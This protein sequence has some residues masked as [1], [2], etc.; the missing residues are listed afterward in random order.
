MSRNVL[1]H[2]EHVDS[3]SCESD[4]GRKKQKPRRMETEDRNPR[5]RETRPRPKRAPE[6]EER[7]PRARETRA[8]PQRAPETVERQPRVLETE[9]RNPR[10]Q[11]LETRQQQ[12]VQIDDEEIDVRTS[13]RQPYVSGP[14]QTVEVPKEVKDTSAAFWKCRLE[15]CDDALEVNAPSVEFLEKFGN[16][17]VGICGGC[18]AKCIDGEE[19]YLDRVGI[20]KHFQEEELPI[21]SE[22]GV[23]VRGTNLAIITASVYNNGANKACLFCAPCSSRLKSSAPSVYRPWKLDFGIADLSLPKLSI[24]E[25]AAI[26]LVRMVGRVVK[27]RFGTRS[28]SNPFSYHGNVLSFPQWISAVPQTLPSTDVHTCIQVIF[29]GKRSEWEGLM[30]QLFGNGG[31]LSARVDA[32]YAWLK[33]LKA[34]NRFYKAVD[35]NFVAGNSLVESFEQIMSGVT[36]DDSEVAA[37]ADRVPDV[38]VN[39]HPVGLAEI[40]VGE[41]RISNGQILLRCAA[42]LKIMRGGQPVNEFENFEF[43][44]CAAFPCIFPYGR[45]FSDGVEFRWSIEIKR[46][47]VLHN[48]GNIERDA[49]LMFFIYNCSNR[50]KMAQNIA[51]AKPDDV[52]RLNDILS[53]AELEHIFDESNNESL[54]VQRAL[55]SSIHVGEKG[56]PFSRTEMDSA[57]CTLLGMIRFR[58]LPTFFVTFS[59]SAFN[60]SFSL[61]ISGFNGDWESYLERSAHVLCHPA[62]AALFFERVKNFIEQ[63]LIKIPKVNRKSMSPNEEIGILGRCI[64]YASVVETQGRTMLHFHSLVWTTISPELISERMRT[65]S[66]DFVEEISRFIDK[67]MCSKMPRDFWDWSNDEWARRSVQNIPGLVQD[68]GERH[69]LTVHQYNIHRVHKNCFRSSDKKEFCRAAMPAGKWPLQT[70]PVMLFIDEKGIMRH[71]TNF[72]RAGIP[73]AHMIQC[74]CSRESFKRPVGNVVY[75]IEQSRPLDE[76]CLL[77]SFIPLMPSFLTSNSHIAGIFTRSEGVIS[78]LYMVKYNTKNKQTLVNCLSAAIAARKRV[79]EKG[80]EATTKTLWNAFQNAFSSGRE[81]PSTAAAYACIGN[82]SFTTT[83]TSRFVFPFDGMQIDSSGDDSETDGSKGDYFDEDGDL[84]KNTSTKGTVYKVG[85]VFHSLRQQDIYNCRDRR[86]ENVALLEF[87]LFFDVVEI[88]DTERRN[89]VFL[90]EEPLPIA[91][92]HILLLRKRPPMP[93]LGGSNPPKCDA[94]S[95]KSSKLWAKY[96]ATLLFPYRGLYAPNYDQESFWTWFIDSLHGKNGIA[97]K[98]KSIFVENCTWGSVRSKKSSE[99]INWWRRRNADTLGVAMRKGN[100]TSGG[101]IGEEHNADALAVLHSIES[102]ML[103]LSGATFQRTCGEK[104]A[105]LRSLGFSDQ[106]CLQEAPTQIVP[107]FE[108]NHCE[109]MFQKTMDY[110]ARITDAQ[111]LVGSNGGTYRI[112]MR[113][114]TLNNDQNAVLAAVSNAFARGESKL[115][116]AQGQAGCGKSFAVRTIMGHVRAA[117]GSD[118]VLCCTPTGV[119]AE[120]LAVG[121]QTIHRGF[122]ISMYAKSALMKENEKVKLARK[123][124]G[125]KLV[126]VD[127]ISMVSATMLQM[128]NGRLNLVAER[129]SNELF[130]GKIILVLGDFYQIPPVGAMSLL[131]AALQGVSGGDLFRKFQVVFLKT[132]VRARESAQKEL[133]SMFMSGAIQRSF[134]PRYLERQDVEQNGFDNATFLVLTNLERSAINRCLAVFQGAKSGKNTY[135]WKKKI[136]G[137]SANQVDGELHHQLTEKVPELLGWFLEGAN[138]VCLH[139]YNPAC[140][141]ANGSFCI[142]RGIVPATEACREIL[143]RQGVGAVFEIQQPKYLL[144]EPEAMLID[145]NIPGVMLNGRKCVVIG[146]TIEEVALNK[147]KINVSSHMVDFRYALTIHKCQGKTLGKVVVCIDKASQRGGASFE[148]LLVACTRVTTNEDLR[149]MP[150]FQ[151]KNHDYIYGLKIKPFIKEWFSGNFSEDGFRDY[152]GEIGRRIEQERNSLSK[153]KNRKEIQS[154]PQVNAPIILDDRL[155]KMHQMLLCEVIAPYSYIR[156]EAIDSYIL[157]VLSNIGIQQYRTGWIL[158]A[159][160]NGDNEKADEL[161]ADR[162]KTIV[163]WYSDGNHYIV[164]T[165]DPLSKTVTSIDS[166]RDYRTDDTC[167]MRRAV[168]TLLFPEGYSEQVKQPLRFQ[169]ESD[170]AIMAANQI[171]FEITGED[172]RLTRNIFHAELRRIYGL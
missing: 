145:E 103:A 77:A 158:V 40:H 105:S 144:L 18:G 38:A 66:A 37:V 50:H 124:Q 35:V 148:Q 107:N 70:C 134:K 20:S 139:N 168:G 64:A 14:F 86:L 72:D 170:C 117:C 131:D 26:S 149:F 8:R 59:P 51:H 79:C 49:A 113:D 102:I 10:A 171:V 9:R 90:L 53:N 110:E 135:Y 68:V 141:L 7:H 95:T 167:E 21:G 46:A 138:G 3:S 126:V 151:G 119:A 123:M 42:A 85:D 1:N 99:L 17:S 11:T 159:A 132:Q 47:M 129:Q 92:T 31:V 22:R 84:A 5:A 41:N 142:F 4:G 116:F 88:I 13:E 169:Y 23:L 2:C 161:L 143:Q 154:N 96:W 101:R 165:I 97:D 57:Y 164:L 83:E 100:L 172:K 39:D 137:A 89:D 62:S 104:D 127:E 133:I 25:K 54:R 130:G 111:T 27:I 125:V 61:R 67:V 140:G 80:I 120:N 156:S 91:S 155:Q 82:N 60:T 58:G 163:S 28:G 32:V 56:L 81:V 36:I 147:K 152:F 109:S 48:S 29:I 15:N 121:A 12:N 146:A 150:P 114:D 162:S 166:L 76:D 6:T 45:V 34:N 71:T 160:M 115:I 93:L 153:K 73:C 157:D 16:Q 52:R 74:S 118:S 30:P 63:E 78:A 44:L 128:I 122:I 98:S 75:L 94:N 43:I 65:G 24:V 19:Q 33:F 108:S 106:L 87:C 136:L 69:K 112:T 55:L